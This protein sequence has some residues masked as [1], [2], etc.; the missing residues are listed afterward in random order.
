MP[1]DP[2]VIIIFKEKHTLL[3]LQVHLQSPFF[4]PF[5]GKSSVFVFY[6]EQES[7]NKIDFFFLM[8]L[9]LLLLEKI[10][11]VC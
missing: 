9:I 10:N 6:I 5:F 4:S 2:A 7:K 11:F 8:K 1:V 3:I